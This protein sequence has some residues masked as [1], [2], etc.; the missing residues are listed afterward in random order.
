MADDF[1][2]LNPGKCGDAM[3]ESAISYPNPPKIRKRPRV[4]IGGENATEIASVTN[5]APQT[6]DYGLVVR[7][8]IDGSDFNV[9]IPIE[10]PGTPVTAFNITTLVPASTETTITNYTVPT[11]KT[12]SFIGFVAS[13]NTN[14]LYKIYVDGNPV[15]AGRSS[16]ATMTLNLTYSLSPFSVTEGLTINLKVTHQ[17][18][19]ACDFEGTILGYI[20]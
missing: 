19:V 13:G 12:F 4:V 9:N 1:T 10:Y 5:S 17:T 7:P 20:K 16:I 11:G 15:L 18:G 8:I 3:D 2:I 6:N 14:A